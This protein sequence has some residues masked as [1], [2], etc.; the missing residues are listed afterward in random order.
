MLTADLLRHPNFKLRATWQT[1]RSLKFACF[2]GC[3]RVSAPTVRVINGIQWVRRTPES[4]FCVEIVLL[5]RRPCPPFSTGKGGFLSPTFIGHMPLN[6]GCWSSAF[7]DRFIPVS[8]AATAHGAAVGLPRSKVAPVHAEM[9]KVFKPFYR[10]SDRA[11]IE[12]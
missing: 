6:G 12:P 7:D 11:N 2:L 4:S 5:S 1:L 10:A 8:D 9:T 3:A